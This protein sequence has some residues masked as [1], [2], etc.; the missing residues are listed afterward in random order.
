MNYDSSHLSFS[1]GEVIVIKGKNGDSGSKGKPGV[2]GSIDSQ[3]G[4]CV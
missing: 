4:G 3:V 2:A 1:S